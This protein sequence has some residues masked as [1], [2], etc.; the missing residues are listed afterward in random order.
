MKEISAN[1]VGK[2]TLSHFHAV[3][4]AV[5]FCFRFIHQQSVLV[6]TH[7]AGIFLRRHS[8]FLGGHSTT[9]ATD[10]TFRQGKIN[11]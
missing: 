3:L 6:V 4:H 10:D 2:Y 5:R 7:A 1:V 9:I 11:L 8:L